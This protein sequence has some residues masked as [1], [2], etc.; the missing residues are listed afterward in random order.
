M[1]HGAVHS[2]TK[3]KTI[4]DVLVRASIKMVTATSSQSR[5]PCSAKL[6]QP[7]AD[8][9]SNTDLGITPL[10]PYTD[11]ESTDLRQ[12]ECN[13]TKG[14]KLSREIRELEQ[15]TADLEQRVD[16]LDIH[17]HNHSE[18]IETLR[19]LKCNPEIMHGGL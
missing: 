10:F 6:H 14:L 16:D 4:W 11:P 19:E 5:S 17:T 13:L 15:R 2:K 18:E 12:F 7:S 8:G 3:P 1:V 9:E